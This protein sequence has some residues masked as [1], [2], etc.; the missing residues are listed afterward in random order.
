MIICY[1]YEGRIFKNN[2]LRFF[3][4]LRFIQNDKTVHL[5]ELHETKSIKKS[6]RNFEGI[7]VL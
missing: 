6:L 3:I 7:L 4:S 5:F 1:S 2:S